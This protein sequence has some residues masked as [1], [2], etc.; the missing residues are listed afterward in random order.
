MFCKNRNRFPHSF[1]T[2]NIIRVRSRKI[3][4]SLSELSSVSEEEKKILLNHN[5]T[6][7]EMLSLVHA[8]NK[9][10]WQEEL[11]FM[12]GNEDKMFWMSSSPPVTGENYEQINCRIIKQKGFRIIY[13]FVVNDLFVF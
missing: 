9:S 12:F 10:T 4:N 2:S 3:L 7:A 8:F 1:Y 5:T 11:N 13:N 6:K